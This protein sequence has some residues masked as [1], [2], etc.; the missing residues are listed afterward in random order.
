[1]HEQ[2]KFCLFYVGSDLEE[3]ICRVE[4]DLSTEGQGTFLVQSNTGWRVYYSII[5]EHI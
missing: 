2:F 4:A 3:E 1:M 5:Y